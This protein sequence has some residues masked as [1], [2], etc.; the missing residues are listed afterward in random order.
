MRTLRQIKAVY[1][2]V[3]HAEMNERVKGIKLASLMKE[4]ERDY[5]M[6]IRRDEDWEKQNH[7][8][9]ALYRKISI[10]KGS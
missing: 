9:M 4:I 6:P 2:K 5:N 8:V 3:L 7:E 1:E 10:S